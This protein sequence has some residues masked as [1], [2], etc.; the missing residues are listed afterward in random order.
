[1]IVLDSV[2][3]RVEVLDPVADAAKLGPRFCAGGFI[4]QVHDR[5][6][7]PLLSGPEY[8]EPNPSPFNAQGLPESFRHRTLEGRPLTWNGLRGVA[9]GSGELE[10]DPTG[11]VALRAPCTWQ[12]A[13]TGEAVTFR[14]RQAAA[15]LDYV[16]ERRIELEDRILRSFTR[17]E[18]HGAATLSLEWF[19]HPFFP[20]VEGRVD[21]HIATTAT[22]PDN[23]GFRLEAG[24]LTAKRRF[25][26]ATDGHMDRGLHLPPGDK[27]HAT[28]VHP[29][30][31]T[32]I[33]ETSF[34]PD[35]FVI[36]GNDRTFSFEPYLT[37]NLAPQAAREWSLSYRFGASSGISAPSE[38]SRTTS[39]R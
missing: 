9:L 30:I 8:P 17:L 7:G 26:S 11:T 37:L 35:A 13:A 2:D 32:L 21:A 19:A 18:N 25:Q 27:F 39:P 5:R 34:A 31:G 4:W 3:L 24:R 16:L 23:P 1:M 10:I 15:G 38:S 36:W 20:L 12:I 33:F 29:T 6:I 28:V 22:L 14:T